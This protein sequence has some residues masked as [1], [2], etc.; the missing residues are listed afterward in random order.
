MIKS[1]ISMI[2][3]KKNAPIIGIAKIWGVVS[4]SKRSKS[5]KGMGSPQ[6]LMRGY[7][8]TG[9]DGQ[10][11]ML[12]IGRGKDSKPHFLLKS[13][14]QTIILNKNNLKKSPMVSP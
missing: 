9:G 8:E 5:T 10:G 13:I 7:V 14:Y 4:F 12:T 1:E 6:K 11:G 3:P 2:F